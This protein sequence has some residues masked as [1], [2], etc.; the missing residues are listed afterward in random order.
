MEEATLGH[1]SSMLY[2]TYREESDSLHKDTKAKDAKY[3]VDSL[4][5]PPAGR[6][7]ISPAK[8][9]PPSSSAIHMDIHGHATASAKEGDMGQ[10]ANEY[11]KSWKL[12]KVLGK[13][14]CGVVREAESRPGNKVRE[15][16]RERKGG[17]ERERE[18]EGERRL[19]WER[20]TKKMIRKR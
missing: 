20:W 1:F 8:T 19:T 2:K 10:V 6:R 17:R 16:G 12:G 14:L 7:H 3:I 5:S 13:G 11:V 15:R 4:V 18:G 9:P